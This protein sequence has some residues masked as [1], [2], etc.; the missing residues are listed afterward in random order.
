MHEMITAAR[1]GKIGRARELHNALT[2]LMDLMFI[3]SNPIPVKA[4]V[5]LLGYSDNSLRLP[6]LPLSGESMERLRSEMKRQ[7]LL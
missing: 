7:G 4:A 2:P 1:E 3:E 6:L 5:S